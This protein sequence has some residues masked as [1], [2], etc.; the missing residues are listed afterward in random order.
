VI[1]EVEH[2]HRPARLTE[3]LDPTQPLF[4]PGRIPRQVD[5]DQRTKGLQVQALTR[6]IRGH[7]ETDLALLDRCL[8]VLALDGSKVITTE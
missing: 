1:H 6:R 7:E 8:D 3:P 2:V 5:V 4:E